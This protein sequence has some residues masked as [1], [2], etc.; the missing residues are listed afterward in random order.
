LYEIGH[1]IYPAAYL[2][3]G[4]CIRYGGALGVNLAIEDIATKSQDDVDSEE[5]RRSWWAILVLDR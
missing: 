2:S 1:G 4:S 5:R 3:I